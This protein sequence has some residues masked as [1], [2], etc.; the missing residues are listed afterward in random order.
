[1][2]SI[3]ITINGYLKGF[4]FLIRPHLLLGWLRHPFLLASNIL[5][6]T[7]WMA[8]QDRKNIFN[9]FYSA[10]RDYAKRYQLYQYII[11]TQPLRGKPF[12]YLEF[13]V[14]RGDSIK[15]W[16]SNCTHKETRFFGFDTFEG[17]PEDW[18]T[19]KKGAMAATIPA[20]ED[21]RV[22]FVKGLFQESVPKFLSTYPVNHATRKVIHLDADLFSST[23]YALTMLAP[24]LTKGDILM[25]D[26]FNV[27]NHEFYA[28]QCFCESYY[29]R[30]KLLG[31]VNNYFQVAMIIIE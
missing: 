12:D 19:F 17:L 20:I 18:G 6:L 28:F 13:G 1:M 21:T 16:V 3:L 11:D 9:D 24:H 29:I 5:R 23:L 8:Q 25:F 2:K 31:A 30:T 27:P 15:W 26:E 10:K 22:Q 7:Q 4:I 14:S